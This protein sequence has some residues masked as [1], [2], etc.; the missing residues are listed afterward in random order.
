MALSQAAAA[1]AAC[2]LAAPFTHLAAVSQHGLRMLWGP[3]AR[4]QSRQ[5]S[6]AAAL[7]GMAEVAYAQQDEPSVADI[8]EAAGRIHS[9]DSFSAVDGPGVRMV[10]FEQVKKPLCTQL[11]TYCSMGWTSQQPPAFDVPQ[12]CAMRCKFCSNPD[13]WSPCSGELV[14]SKG[15]AVQ[16]RRCVLAFRRTALCHC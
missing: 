14:S 13:T 15:I 1:A 10:V 8:P 5:A 16:L 2:Q 9:V 3:S 11:S 7:R 6:G 12:G 4:E